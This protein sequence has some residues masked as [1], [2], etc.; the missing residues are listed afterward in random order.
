MHNNEGDDVSWFRNVISG[1]AGLLVVVG[2]PA[3]MIF[4]GAKEVLEDNP[5]DANDRLA[6]ESYKH[7]GK[8]FLEGA[9]FGIYD[10]DEGI[11]AEGVGDIIYDAG[12]NTLEFTGNAATQI[13]DRASKDLEGIELPSANSTNNPNTPSEPDC[14]DMNV[15][16][17]EEKCWELDNL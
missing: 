12:K 7:D 10:A 17:I 15:M 9:T 16:I 6:T 1:A 13:F 4:N 14:D 11:T 2:L 5:E 3:V 8:Q